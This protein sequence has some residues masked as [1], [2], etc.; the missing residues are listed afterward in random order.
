M[1]PRASQPPVVPTTRMTEWLDLMLEEIE[2]KKKEA[3]EAEAERARRDDQRSSDS[4][5][6]ANPAS[7]DRRSSAEVTQKRVG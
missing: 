7:D 1:R 4:G 3:R 6:S 2:R 5:S